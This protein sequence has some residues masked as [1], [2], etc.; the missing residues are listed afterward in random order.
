M[1]VKKL[2]A[3]ILR[4]ARTEPVVIRN[5]AAGVVNVLIALNVINTGAGQH[6][7]A[8]I[9]VVLQLVAMFSARAR[10]TPE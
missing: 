1:Q 8:A 9:G 7:D 10:V 6:V 4:V 3:R 5:A 2:L